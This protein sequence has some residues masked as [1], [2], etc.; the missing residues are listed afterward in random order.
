MQLGQRM[1][2][3]ASSSCLTLTN[4]AS[5]CCAGR[6]RCDHPGVDANDERGRKRCGGALMRPSV[7]L[8]RS[9]APGAAVA[10]E[11]AG[12]SLSITSGSSVAAPEGSPEG[13]SV[14]A[15]AACGSCP[16]GC[17]R[18]SSRN[19]AASLTSLSA[20]AALP[21]RTPTHCHTTAPPPAPPPYPP[22]P[23]PTRVRQH[24]AIL[25]RTAASTTSLYIRLQLCRRVHQRSTI[26]LH[27]RQHCL[28]VPTIL[29]GSLDRSTLRV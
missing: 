9:M 8:S 11:A 22:S 3:R 7:E 15:C 23:I 2:P 20:S 5:P 16:C 17:P 28:L 1:I 19:P 12:A 4:G 14:V 10:A 24:P 27:R 21:T 6:L 26:L 13:P 25:P 18:E 29:H